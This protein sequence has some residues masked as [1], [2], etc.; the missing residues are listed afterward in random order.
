[1]LAAAQVKCISKQCCGGNHG[2]PRAEK[3]RLCFWQRRVSHQPTTRWLC[4]CALEYAV[5][6]AVLPPSRPRACSL[7][8]GPPVLLLVS[9]AAVLDRGQRRH[10]L[11]A[12]SS[13]VA[14]KVNV[15]VG[16]VRTTVSGRGS[17]QCAV[18]RP[19]SSG[20]SPCLRSTRP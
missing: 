2:C 5:D 4:G 13:V 3:Q 10:L 9:P 20:P 1:V 11:P 7:F 16:V 6:S 17:R 14:G 15:R 19:T 18:R 12:W 8:H